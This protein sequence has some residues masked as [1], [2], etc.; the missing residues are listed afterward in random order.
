MIE[1]FA[2]GGYEEVGRNS[3]AIKVGDDV[4]IF[5]LGLHIERVLDLNMQREYPSL[6]ALVNADAIPNLSQLAPYRRNVRA[7]IANHAHL[8]H[9][10]A[11]PILANY[12]PA[13]IIS[14]PYSTGLIDQLFVDAGVKPK[15][16]FLTM[17]PNESIDL[18]GMELE[19]ISMTHS[20][21]HT[22]FSV[23][24]TDEGAIVYANDY[25][26]DAT[27]V[28]GQK[29]DFKRLKQLGK[30]GV[31]LLV[32]ESVRIERKQKTPSEKVARLLLEG[33]LLKDHD[34]GL[35]ITTFASHIER[36]KSIIEIG[37]RLGRKILLLGRS[38]LKHVSIAKHLNLLDTHKLITPTKKRNVEFW[39]RKVMKNRQD[40]LVLCTGHQGE[41]RSILTRLA[42]NQL[43]YKFAPQ[44]EVIFSSDVIPSPINQ[45][46]FYQL[47][48]RL[49]G[50]GARLF[51]H[52]HVSGHASKE[53]HRD[54]IKLLRPEHIVPCHGDLT[55]LARFAELASS[56]NIISEYTE[57]EYNL[58]ETIHLLHNGKRHTIQ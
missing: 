47:T 50:A 30:E 8:D 26:F 52:V 55:K 24:H 22:V 20:I 4:V 32:V 49:E 57:R 6:E 16:P 41:P 13:S 15:H 28:L 37:A 1:V 56:M 51:E 42:H 48:K 5:D 12:Y 27:P 11:M 58:G 19:F 14:T 23:L 40:Y 18:G 17:N 54:L 35:F 2:L 33:V 53:D 31:R 21:P 25:K 3:T 46:N 44:D 39:L 10:G 34:G 7:I 38:L 36:I 9:V 43:P 45:E 29:P